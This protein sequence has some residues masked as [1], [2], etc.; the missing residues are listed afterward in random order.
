MPRTDIL[1]NDIN[2]IFIHIK[3]SVDLIGRFKIIIE[4][5][6]QMETSNLITWL[7]HHENTN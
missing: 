6:G 1:R 2:I 4:I 7:Y 3:N 5:N